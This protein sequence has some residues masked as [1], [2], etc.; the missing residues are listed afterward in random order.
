[1]TFVGKVCAAVVVGPAAV[2]VCV[3]GGGRRK[4]K[5]ENATAK[6]RQA[7][8]CHSGFFVFSIHACLQ[9]PMP[10]NNFVCI[11]RKGAAADGTP[12]A[13]PSVVRIGDE[14]VETLPAADG[15]E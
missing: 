12:A 10:A 6:M 3:G 13:F 5:R 15:G 2:C 1:M 4:G 11:Y 8:P 7:T 9:I 14:D